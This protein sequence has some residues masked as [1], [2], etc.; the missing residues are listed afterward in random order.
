M[1]P[2][3]STVVQP[4]HSR[5][6][7]DLALDG[8]LGLVVVVTPDGAVLDAND[9]ACRW[10]TAER[11][12]LVGRK[13]WETPWWTAS[14]EPRIRDAVG[15]AQQ[16]EVV[17]LEAQIVGSVDPR[18]VE[19]SF[20]PVR[21][22][23]GTV[24]LVVVEGRD[25]TEQRGA[26]Q[27]L[28]LSERR[29]S[30]IIA[31][32]A[33]AIVSL[34]EHHRIVLF[35]HGAERIFGW[36]A[37]EVVG[38]PIDVLIPDH[39]RPAHRKHLDKLEG[40]G[41]VTRR[42]TERGQIHGR[43][44]D[45]RLFP[46]EAS[47]SKF[48]VAGV[49]VMTAVVRDVSDRRAMEERDRMLLARETAARAA[50]E[51]AERRQA[52]LAE[53]STVLDASLDYDSTLSALARLLV[54]SLATFCVID[55]LDLES[56]GHRVE[57][58]HG[59]PASDALAARLR[60]YPIDP[61]HG[62]FARQAIRGESELVTELSEAEIAERAR[63]ASH[64][65]VLRTLGPSS[66]LS[67]PMRAHGI[68]LGA[69][70]LFGTSAGRRLRASDLALAE[71]V[72]ERA[73][74]AVDN[75]RLYRQALRASQMRDRTLGIVSH[76]LRGPLAAIGMAARGIERALGTEDEARPLVQTV[77]DA[78]Q[79]M[80]RLIQDLLDVANIE[81]GRFALE[82]QSVDPVVLLVRASTLFES[83]AEER[84]VTL[85]VDLPDHLPRIHADPERL[86]QVCANLLD[87]AVKYTPS[88]GSVVVRG[89]SDGD[90]VI[91]EIVDSGAGIPADELPHVFERFWHAR[92]GAARRGSGLGLAIAKEI[93]ELHGGS[94]SIG[95]MP[96][97]GTS[98]RFVI[99]IQRGAE[100]PRRVVTPTR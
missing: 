78:A 68:V 12:S 42:M 91:I 98:C 48:D 9:T 14:D 62:S 3:S 16:G 49:P 66:F 86:L 90:R 29:L 17:R 33:E 39:L 64:L 76:D 74:I 20:C 70:T 84:G 69:V 85:A 37:E 93:V 97:R 36:T 100:A 47:I 71:E 28:R 65:E 27:T 30:G 21:A 56:G 82:R 25:V 34:D 63:D 8:I 7:R 38:R 59:D 6:P 50:A 83:A 55:T 45:G 40:E 54:P 11:E 80:Q 51:A 95:S 88:G 13:L 73:A 1:R 18:I 60:D 5:S 15:R 23:N 32:A 75:A 4:S 53:V 87:N 24:H 99:P 67:V 57:V 52:F 79:L 43:R 77:L 44:K 2:D 92:H 89:S 81:A 41:S 22:V 35:N 94:I 31:L 10:T 96:A 61:S 19:L 26:E 58:A 46:A 72:A